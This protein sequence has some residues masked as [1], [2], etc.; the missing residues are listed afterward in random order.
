M[1]IDAL[2]DDVAGLALCL[3]CSCLLKLSHS[4]GPVFLI[5][6]KV[7]SPVTQAE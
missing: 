3:S 4:A 2:K 5:R 6:G 7:K 1:G